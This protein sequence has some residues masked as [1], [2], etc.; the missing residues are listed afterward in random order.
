MFILP[1]VSQTKVTHIRIP[2]KVMEI[3]DEHHLFL[4]SCRSQRTISGT[5]PSL[6]KTVCQ[7]LD[8]GQLPSEEKAALKV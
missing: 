3:N 6:E 1:T 8:L 7:V 5:I 2:Q 4:D